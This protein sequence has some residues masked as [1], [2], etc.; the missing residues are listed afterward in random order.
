MNCLNFVRGSIQ[1]FPDWPPGAMVQLCTTRCR[2]IAILWASLVSFATITLCLASRQVFIVVSVY[3][4]ID[5]VRKL[6]DTPSY[7]RIRK[8]CVD[9]FTIRAYV[10]ILV[11]VNVY[12]AIK[13]VFSSINL[14]YIRDN[15]STD[16][17]C[18]N[19]SQLQRINL[20]KSCKDED[21]C[22]CA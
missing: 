16:T 1:K 20:T 7:T 18:M 22:P 10:S 8:I 3:F 14:I 17:I 9:L 15:T 4:V 12:T 21:S 19:E 11:I 5:S 6:L 13:F 2:C